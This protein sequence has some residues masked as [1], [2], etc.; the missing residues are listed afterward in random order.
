[1]STCGAVV[2][3]E[4]AG[5]Y[6]SIL[7][8]F[9]LLLSSAAIGAPH[10][11]GRTGRLT[12]FV[13]QI[14][15]TE[16]H[17]AAEAYGDIRDDIPVVPLLK[18]SETV[19][20]A[21]LTSDFVSTT[22]YSGKPIHIIVA[23]D[24][25]AVVTGVRLV[26]H[27]EPI[28]L[29]GIPERKIKALTE[30]YAGL[31]LKT[32]AA[33]GGTGH[34]LDIISGATVT[35]VVIDDSIVRGGIKVARALG[36]GGLGESPLAA[37]PAYEVDPSIVEPRSW[38]ELSREG[39]ISRLTL[40]V[41]QINQAFV[42]S[43]DA[44]AAARP[45]PGDESQ[46]FIDLYAAPASVPAIG[47]SILG[48]DEFQNM[49]A[50]LG[51][52]EQA[53]VVAGRGRYSFKGSGYVR[54]GLFDRIH[55][56]QGDL[57]VRFRDRQHRR[58]GQVAAADAPSF[59]E[60]DLFTIP[61]D[62]GFDPALPWRLQLLVNRSIGAVEK[63]YLTFDLAYHLP[64]S[65][66]R[67][68]GPPAGKP[69][70][71]VRDDITEAAA[72]AEAVPAFEEAANRVHEIHRPTWRNEKHA[73][74][75]INSLEA[76]AFPVLGARKV[77]DIS[78]ADV[79]AV[80]QPIWLE[81]PETARRV[82]QRIGTVMKWSIA[83]GWR[84]DNPAENIANA[85]PKHD[86]AK[87]HRKALPYAE[88]AGCIDTVKASGAWAATK[89]ALEFLVLTAARSGEVRL[90][91][92]DEVEFQGADCATWE[93]PA[94]RMKMKRPHRVPLPKRAQEILREAEALRGGSGLI[95]PSAR[96]KPLSDMTLSKLVKELGFDADVHGFRTSFR[97]WAQEQTN[98]PR[99]VAEAALA[100]AIGDAVE[101]AYA[102]SDVFDKR[103]KMMAAWANYLAVKRG[104]VVNM[105]G[106][107]V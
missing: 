101:N 13:S 85:L 5:V 78:T 58:L 33:A 36:L 18:R 79:L 4:S 44:K 84:H 42:D 103:A 41:G 29:I 72:K 97:T 38:Q 57:S 83:Q 23:V 74:D 19:G 52:G 98:F 77:S 99:E 43:G 76:Y 27:A 47:K 46:T 30:R 10:D 12:E 65:Y 21:F 62:T 28:I 49:R 63:S 17:S 80:L 67:A 22:G 90:A 68:I 35:I 96:G 1:V 93:I 56:I 86:R 88:V 25:D 15:P 66:T 3:L 87:V 16:L 71:V 61:A 60:L 107:G 37:G 70:V 82:R 59:T 32:E 106:A 94:S 14:A 75:F 40:D 20:W 95:F 39:A 7:A 2:T 102:R 48:E 51:E 9:C 91:H 6:R 24:L 45:E 53:I 34:D 89:L 92:W 8:A 55:L 104:E 73:R 81:K 31:D 100:H 11:P 50:D 54:G 64:R 105:I 69:I 26:E